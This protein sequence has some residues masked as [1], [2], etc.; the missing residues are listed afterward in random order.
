[1]RLPHP[2]PRVNSFGKEK[3]SAPTEIGEISEIS[4]ISS[5]IQMNSKNLKKFARTS[6]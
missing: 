6:L 4:E 5:Q 1:M 2:P 3:N